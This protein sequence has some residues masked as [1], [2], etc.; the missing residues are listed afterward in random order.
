MYHKYNING[1]F[2]DF[3][4][5][6]NQ[7]NLD[8]ENHSFVILRRTNC[9]NCGLFSYFIVYLGCINKYISLGYI[10]IID[11]KSFPNIFNKMNASLLNSNPWELK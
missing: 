3:D 5:N 8:Y 6:K 10:P 2:M 4:I 7:I 11:L 9:R 1:N